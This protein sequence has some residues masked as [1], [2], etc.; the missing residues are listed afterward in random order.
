MRLAD[1]YFSIAQT[2]KSRHTFW[3]GVKEMNRFALPNRRDKDAR[4]KVLEVTAGFQP[5][6]ADSMLEW[7]RQSSTLADLDKFDPYYL[8]GKDM[9]E[10]V[11]GRVLNNLRFRY[12]DE[13][14]GNLAK[15]LSQKAQPTFGEKVLLSLT[16]EKAVNIYQMLGSEFKTFS[17][18]P[19]EQQIK[20]AKFASEINTINR[21]WF[22]KQSVTDLPSTPESETARERCQQL[23]GD[24]SSSKSVE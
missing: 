4:G 16:Q 12:H 19:K 8:S 22:G 18:L 2:L 23:L 7:L 15:R 10:S 6:E 24:L 20:L 11:W 9:E 17:T 1:D 14:K 21:D 3:L 13:L 5:D